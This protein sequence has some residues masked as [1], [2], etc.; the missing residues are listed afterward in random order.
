M[1]KTIIARSRMRELR[2][3]ARV[4]ESEVIE[5]Q[6]DKT[7]EYAKSFCPV[8]NDNDPGHVHMRDTIKTVLRGR[9]N[10]EASV[11]AAY[12]VPVNFGTINRPADPFWTKAG[13][14]VKREAGVQTHRIWT[15]HL[16]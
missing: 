10:R 11:G 2:L 3:R 4:A 12:G 15:K 5:W 8:S 9:L 1:Y 16:K 14:Q 6:A 13:E 7:T